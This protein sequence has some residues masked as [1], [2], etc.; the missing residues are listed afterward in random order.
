MR[1]S[2]RDEAGLVRD[3][4]ELNAV[5][6]AELS[7][8]AGDMSLDCQGTQIERFCDFAIVAS[9]RD[10]AQHFELARAEFVQ[11]LRGG[12]C[13]LIPGFLERR[14]DGT[15]MVAGSSTRGGS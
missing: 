2:G 13:V 5:A 10:K 1:R 7:E 15:D 4:D 11:S 3:H 6:G 14:T 12:A 8:D 9:L